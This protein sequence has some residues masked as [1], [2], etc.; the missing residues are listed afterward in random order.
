MIYLNRLIYLIVLSVALSASADHLIFNRVCVNP[1]EAELIEIYNPTDQAIDLSNYYLSDQN[2]Y[3][4]WVFGNSS[5]LSSRDFLI[6][7]PD[8]SQ[9]EAEESFLIS[10]I[11]NDDFFDYYDEMPDISLID[12]QFFLRVFLVNDSQHF[13]IFKVGVIRTVISWF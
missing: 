6:K 11:S 9:I 12:T 5:T 4:N 3:Y 1:N 13:F 2:D 8:G 10:T 7:F